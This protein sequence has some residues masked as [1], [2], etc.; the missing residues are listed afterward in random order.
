MVRRAR[1]DMA[2][3]AAT[4]EMIGADEHLKHQL[5]RMTLGCE[6]AI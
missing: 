5:A 2:V 6:A 3:I 1:S 4:D